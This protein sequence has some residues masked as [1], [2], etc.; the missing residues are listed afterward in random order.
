MK[1]DWRESLNWGDKRGLPR[2]S[3]GLQIEENHD[4]A[5]QKV[6]LIGSSWSLLKLEIT[7]KEP[8]SM[9]QE[10][11]TIVVVAWRESCSDKRCFPLKPIGFHGSLRLNR[12]SNPSSTRGAKSTYW[13]SRL[14]VKRPTQRL[15]DVALKKI[16]P[17]GLRVPPEVAFAMRSW[18]LAVF[19]AF[20]GQHSVTAAWATFSPWSILT[21]CQI[22]PLLAI[23]RVCSRCP[24]FRRLEDDLPLK[25][26][27]VVERL[28]PEQQ[29]AMDAVIEWTSSLTW[30][31]WTAHVLR[32]AFKVVNLLRY[33]Q[34]LEAHL[35]PLPQSR[36]F[37][38]KSEPWLFTLTMSILSLWNYF[39]KSVTTNFG[40]IPQWL[41]P[42]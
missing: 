17:G 10:V 6:L 3:L 23:L 30:V 31:K 29:L 33:S 18:F 25:H 37:G 11:S 38:K 40:T 4:G 24:S 13:V 39:P 5:W 35:P 8:F 16:G 9:W 21:H 42:D 2:S 19:S 36:Q 20:Y 26:S 41:L 15:L 7:G 14:T 32:E 22:S 27:S 1:I 12:E 34:S 28:L